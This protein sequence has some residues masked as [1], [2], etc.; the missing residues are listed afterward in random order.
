MEKIINE[1]REGGYDFTDCDCFQNNEVCRGLFLDPLFFQALGKACGWKGKVRNCDE[2]SCIPVIFPDHFEEKWIST[3][4]DFHKI[5]LTSDF[6]T[7][8]KWLEELITK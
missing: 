8:V 6:P 5:N 4:L 3:A 1:A 2:P 7:A